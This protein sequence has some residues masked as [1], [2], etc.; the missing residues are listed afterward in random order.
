[1]YYSPQIV[2]TNGYYSVCVQNVQKGVFKSFRVKSADYKSF[3][4]KL[5]SS[6]NYISLGQSVFYHDNSVRTINRDEYIKT[7][8]FHI[9]SVYLLDSSSIY[10]LESLIEKH[11]LTIQ[12]LYV[13]DFDNFHLDQLKKLNLHKSNLQQITFEKCESMYSAYFESN[14]MVEYTTDIEAASQIQFVNNLSFFLEARKYY[15]VTYKRIFVENGKAYRDP[16]FKTN[17]SLEKFDRKQIVEALEQGGHMDFANKENTF[18]C[19]H[20]EYKNMCYD[21]RE[22]FYNSV[23]NKWYHKQ[24][25][26]YNPYIAKWKGEDGYRTLQECGVISNENGF[27]IDHEMI[28]KINLELWGEDEA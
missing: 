12:S 11:K 20:C 2:V 23:I 26:N 28:A 8:P 10:V 21:L 4:Y 14:F 7:L 5:K 13:K 22:P 9:S 18:I 24:E 3:L 6:L 19:S 15:P 1:M 17:C 25:C 27:S 16:W